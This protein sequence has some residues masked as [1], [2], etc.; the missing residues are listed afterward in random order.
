M[1]IRLPEGRYVP[2]TQADEGVW[3]RPDNPV[4]AV[5]NGGLIPAA[6]VFV[7]AKTYS[8]QRW[9]VFYTG[10]QEVSRVEIPLPFR[11]LPK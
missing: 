10:I 11:V 7:P 1:R 6:G 5:W 4:V 3:Y 2:F 9:G 8:D